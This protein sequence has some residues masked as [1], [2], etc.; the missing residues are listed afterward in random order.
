[1]LDMIFSPQVNE[2]AAALCKAQA[3]FPVL[4]KDSRAEIGEAWG[5]TEFQVNLKLGLTSRQESSGKEH[6]RKLE[7]FQMEP[8]R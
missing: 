3:V 2:I 8:C 6:S 7:T 4:S 1:M 5:Q